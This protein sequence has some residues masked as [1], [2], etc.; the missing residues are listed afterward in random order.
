MECSAIL[1][2]LLLFELC[3]RDWTAMALGEINATKLHPDFDLN[4]HSL[5]R[6][7]LHNC[8]WQG[9]EKRGSAWLIGFGLN[10]STG[11]EPPPSSISLA[12][13]DDGVLQ[14]NSLIRSAAT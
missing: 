5:R 3:E 13:S 10:H 12:S 14:W 2:C 11:A 9:F 7:T 6:F 4:L 1:V 8:R